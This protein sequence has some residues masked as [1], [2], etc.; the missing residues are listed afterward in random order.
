[1]EVAPVD[2]RHLDV[3]AALGQPQ[4]CLQTG[5]AAADDHDTMTSG[6]RHPLQATLPGEFEFGEPS[7]ASAQ[8]D[9]TRRAL[10]RERP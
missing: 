4:R 6:A 9:A 2:D 1:V 3:G 5:E 10:A 8:V 7:S